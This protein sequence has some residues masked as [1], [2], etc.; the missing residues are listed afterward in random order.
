MKRIMKNITLLLILAL[1]F[2]ACASET[3][4][5]TLSGESH[6]IQIALGVE[7]NSRVTEAGDNIYNENTIKEVDIFFY[8]KIDDTAPVFYPEQVSIKS[9]DGEQIATVTVP[10]DMVKAIFGKPFT[11]YAIANKSMAIKPNSTDAYNR[12]DLSNKSI[13]QLQQEL[14]FTTDLA[15]TD[16]Q[17]LFLMEGYAEAI[18]I[19][20]NSGNDVSGTVNLTRTASKI[21]L[22]LTVADNIEVTNGKTTMT[23]VPI[24]EGMIVQLINGVKKSY[25]NSTPYQPN[26]GE[27]ILFNAEREIAEYTYS[28][29]TE[30]SKS[31]HVPFYSYST[32]WEKEANTEPYLLLGVPWKVQN[33]TGE[34][35]PYYYYRIPINRKHVN[36]D[37]TYSL[38]R[39]HLYRI[40]LNVG[41]LGSL[42]K[43]DAIEVEADYSIVDWIGENI[44][45]DLQNYQYLIVDK[46]QVIVY[47]KPD[48]KVNY[49]TSD[50]VSYQILSITRPD[51]GG[52]TATIENIYTYTSGG[53]ELTS[54]NG[55]TLTA[56]NGVLNL[57]HTLDNVI[58]DGSFDYAPYTIKVKI[59]HTNNATEFVE[60]VEFVQ[61]PAV[62]VVNSYNPGGNIVEKKDSYNWGNYPY[63]D[64]GTEDGYEDNG[65]VFVNSQAQ[66]DYNGGIWNTVDGFDT[67][68]NNPNMYIVTTT[69]LDR[70][71][72][73]ILGDSR[74][75]TTYTYS[76]IGTEDSKDRYNNNLQKYRPTKIDSDNY[77]SPQFRISSAYGQLG[78]NEL[79]KTGAK[80]RCAAYQEY[81]YPA[82]RWRLATKAELEFIAILCQ[83]DAL[84][85]SLFGASTYWG[86]NDRYTIDTSSGKIEAQGDDG[87]AYL[88]C[89]YDDWYW[90]S[91]PLDDK[92]IFTWG[93][94]KT[95][96]ELNE[97]AKQASN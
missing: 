61:Y 84:P 22:D 9:V 44:S 4:E 66:K 36:E 64:D 18:T 91:E 39:N 93:D 28:P 3:M 49:V 21:I 33:E 31:G 65:W 14:P 55:F 79:D 62:Y 52:T 59:Y 10:T 12:A 26:D 43:G 40:K 88:R 92:T 83:Y 95:T 30:G 32:T 45:T 71:L 13:S 29:T 53:N 70:N 80:K 56:E 37:G 16:G 23:Y 81:G 24:K 69:A 89:V 60:E 11:V 42:E 7:A 46:K 47:N 27:T 74:E 34:D 90:G 68:S 6:T 73:Y 15:D 63:D 77:L 94:Q 97:L 72:N 86:A 35:F 25:I 1:Y 17:S 2:T 41:V 78:D 54:T 82:G 48:C 58:S 96:A 75:T 19:A 87:T 20:E 8:E 51:Y 38:L 50:V 67:S 5:L 85:S 57:H 76:D